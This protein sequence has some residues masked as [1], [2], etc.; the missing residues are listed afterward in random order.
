M[1]PRRGGPCGAGRSL[2][3]HPQLARHARQP[4]IERPQPDGIEQ[5]RRAR[6]SSASSRMRA[7]TPTSCQ[8]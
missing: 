6:S 5:R 3:G 4:G 2:S 8:A 1:G 7:V